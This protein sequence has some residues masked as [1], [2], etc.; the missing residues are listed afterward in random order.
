MP[1]SSFSDQVLPIAKPVSRIFCLFPPLRQEFQ[2]DTRGRQ[3]S[4]GHLP[5]AVRLTVRPG[6]AGTMIKASGVFP[7]DRPIRAGALSLRSTLR[8]Q[9]G[10]SGQYRRRG[11]GAP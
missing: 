4:G 7:G 9:S 3:L 8:V 11:S 2:T 5:T 6:A 1:R 10:R